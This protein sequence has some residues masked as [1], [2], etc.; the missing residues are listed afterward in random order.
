[1]RRRRVGVD[2]GAGT[3]PK[4]SGS[5]LSFGYASSR[6]LV[7]RGSG[8]V[9]F[10]SA[11]IALIL[12]PLPGGTSAP[13]SSRTPRVIASSLANETY[14]NPRLLPVPESV[15]TRTD[16][17]VP[18]DDTRSR[19]KLSNAR[20]SA[21]LSR[22]TNARWRETAT[23]RRSDGYSAAA[24]RGGNGPVDS[25][26]RP[27]EHGA[28]LERGG[29]TIGWMIGAGWWAKCPPPNPPPDPPGRRRP[30]GERRRVRAGR[31]RVRRSGVGTSPRVARGVEDERPARRAGARAE[32][33]LAERHGLP[34]RG[35]GGESRRFPR[36]LSRAV[37]WPGGS[38]RAGGGFPDACG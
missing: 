7:L 21:D 34:R 14:A 20:S 3:L 37:R 33:R 4:R 38:S 8:I 32:P 28:V 13:S 30:R 29:G 22:T 1:M 9:V 2:A 19:T 12:R 17:T 24:P 16:R 36:R 31:R 27:G 5:P 25:S 6:V 18:G 35:G 15:T 26:L 23:P 11:G 10:S